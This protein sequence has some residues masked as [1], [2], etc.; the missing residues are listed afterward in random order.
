MIF[1]AH[2][3][4]MPKHS[5]HACIH[6]RRVARPPSRT[7]CAWHAKSLGEKGVVP[8]QAYAAAAYQKPLLACFF[9]GLASK[10]VITF[11]CPLVLPPGRTPRTAVHRQ[12]MQACSSVNSCRI[13]VAFHRQLMQAPGFGRLEL[14]WC[15]RKILLGWL[16]LERVTGV[17]REEITVALEA[18]RPAERSE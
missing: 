8:M 6:V 5:S 10:S 1:A 3:Q 11:L 2:I 13:F 4:S 15:E 18:T 12:L 16:E 14:E 9:R 17:V 7:L